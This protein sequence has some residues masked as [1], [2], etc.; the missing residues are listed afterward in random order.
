MAETSV[1]F[2]LTIE[3]LHEAGIIMNPARAT[4]SEFFDS[5]VFNET[6][7]KTEKEYFDSRGESSWSIAAS[8]SEKK[9]NLGLDPRPNIMTGRLMSAMTYPV[10][11]GVSTG[12]SFSEGIA[13]REHDEFE[14]KWGPNESHPEFQTGDEPYPRYAAL[15][16]PFAIVTDGLAEKVSKLALEY[17][18]DRMKRRV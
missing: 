1:G 11:A 17:I 6:V 4:F 15:K 5:T 8:W 14:M 16:N 12:Y 7:G 18:I 9:L 3:G 13:L 2:D 10:D